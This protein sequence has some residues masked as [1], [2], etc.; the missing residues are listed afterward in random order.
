MASVLGA[1]QDKMLLT[2]SWVSLTFQSALD[3]PSLQLLNTTFWN[4]QVHLRMSLP[5]HLSTWQTDCRGW[6]L[7]TSPASKK[8]SLLKLLFKGIATTA[9]EVCVTNVSGVACRK[10]QK[11]RRMLSHCSMASSEPMHPKWKH[12][13]KRWKRGWRGALSESDWAFK[14]KEDGSV[15]DKRDQMC[16]CLLSRFHSRYEQVLSDCQQCY[17]QQRQTLLGPSVSTAVT[18]LAAKHSRDHCALVGS[19]LCHPE[20]VFCQLP[21][22]K[23]FFVCVARCAVAVPSWFISVRMSTNCTHTSSP[24]WHLYWSEF[25]AYLE[26][27]LWLP[28]TVCSLSVWLLPDTVC[29]ISVWLLAD[30]VCSLSVWLLR[31]TVCSLSV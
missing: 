27:T 21:D 30:A 22:Y 16:S 25:I 1:L 20:C 29:S 8:L 17:F 7:P 12:W 2:L 5:S 31:D 23:C 24:S 13:W 3:L 10:S 11:T 15:P 14:S 4:F 18:E 19:W 9:L 28:D 6:F 26:P